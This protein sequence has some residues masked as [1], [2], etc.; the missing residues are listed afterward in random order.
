MFQQRDA[1]QGKTA[2]NRTI[3]TSS[4]GNN[5]HCFLGYHPSSPSATS[6]LPNRERPNW[7]EWVETRRLPEFQAAT[8]FNAGDYFD[9]DEID[10][11]DYS[12]PYPPLLEFYRGFEILWD[13]ELWIVIGE[14]TWK[15]ETEYEDADEAYAV[16]CEFIDSWWATQPSPGQLIIPGLEEVMAS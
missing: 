10:D 16:A 1:A 8:D 2:G 4:S 9:K 14:R 6:L 12:S 13:A 15:C 5:Y 3:P 11:N 7:P